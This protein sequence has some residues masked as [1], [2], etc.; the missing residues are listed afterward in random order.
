MPELS[1]NI[2]VSSRNDF[3]RKRLHYERRAVRMLVKVLKEQ[4]YYLSN[5]VSSDVILEE[6]HTQLIPSEGI[7]GFFRTFY[8]DIASSELNNVE[9]NYNT[10]RLSF[11]VFQLIGAYINNIIDIKVNEIMRA[12]RNIVMKYIIDNGANDIEKL[13]KA[14]DENNNIPS[15]ALKIARTETV[16]SLNLSSLIKADA[17]RYM[18]IK[19]W[20]DSRDERVRPAST[21]NGQFNHHSSKILPVPYNEPFEV[22]GELL[23]FPGDISLGASAGNT[24]NCR[25]A[26]NFQSVVDRNGRLVIKDRTVD[27]LDHLL[28]FYNFKQQNHGLQVY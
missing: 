23:M 21:L 11:D 15:R 16:S 19:Y 4:Y 17:S 28:N 24:I 12:T 3:A 25:C 13:R 22:S 10:K 8:F 7:E 14:V 2:L 20:V 5:N 9:Y 1:R 27:N 18:K 26:A 6:I